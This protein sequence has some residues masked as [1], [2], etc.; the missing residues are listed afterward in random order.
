MN[1]LHSE[2]NRL[3]SPVDEQGMSRAMVM[4]LAQPA[5]WVTLAGVWHGVQ[6]E[7]ALP[8]PAIAVSG[9]DGLQLWFSVAEPIALRQA[10]A[11]LELLRARFLPDVSPTRVRLM[12]AP[13]APPAAPVPAEQ[14]LTGNWS[15]FVAPDLAAVFAET[16]WLDM[17]PSE[18]GQA[19]L[20]RGLQP[21]K[22]AT[23]EA[24]LTRLEED[25]VPSSV[26]AA[27]PTAPPDIRSANADPR[28]FLARIMNDETVALALRIEA[29]KALLPYADE[30]PRL[31]EP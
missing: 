30:P 9:I 1:R 31:L 4:E 14:A 11:F 6:S 2:L 21:M 19:A 13:D 25:A 15:A 17:S 8:A 7:L 20:L 23:F 22:P 29:A 10:H 5:D 27:H 28:S 18:E 16:P 24:A 26:A 3:Y 12:P